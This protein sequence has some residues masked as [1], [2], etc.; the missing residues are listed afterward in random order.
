MTPNTEY[1]DGDILISADKSK[2]DLKVI[3]GFLSKTYW[4]EGITQD[5]VQKSI[6]HSLCFGVYHK[7]R[8]IGF[9]RIISDFTTF[10]Y[11]ADVFILKDFRGK[12][13]SKKLMDCVLSHPDLQRL[14]K[15]MLATLDAHGLY[16]QYGFR[17][18]KNPE[19]MMELHNP[20]YLKK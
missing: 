11:L 2:L 6:D 1:R 20:D 15:W 19:Y 3:H 5:L 4:A 7:N 14:R 13:L 16:K 17:Q 12:G 9:A 8:Q 18:L 10:A